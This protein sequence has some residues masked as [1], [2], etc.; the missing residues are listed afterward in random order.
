M[1]DE[2]NLTVHL[3]RDF[4]APVA[5][6][7]AAWKDPDFITKWWKNLTVAK[8][9]FREGGAIELRWES[10]D[11]VVTGHYR[12]IVE[13][14]RIVFTWKPK[15]ADESGDESVV[16]LAFEQRGDF[17]RLTLAHELNR[18]KKEA[19]SHHGGWT[20]ALEDFGATY[21]RV[22]SPVVVKRTVNADAA[23]VFAALTTGKLLDQ[24]FFTDCTAD[25]RVDGEYEIKWDSN[26]DPARAHKRF[27]RY[28]DVVE[29]ERIQFEWRGITLDTGD[30]PTIVTVELTAHGEQTDITLSHDGWGG[31][32]GAFESR[33]QHEM[34]WNF[35]VDNLGRYLTSGPDLRGAM[36]DQRVTS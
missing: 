14:E 15:P 17:T 11:G 8:L 10:W 21:P 28:L 7:F 5:K 3:Q 29:N 33:D 26:S 9:D 19:D 25:A 18:S 36:F 20:Q 27:G 2:L 1:S 30:T 35:Y 6:V 22:T 24:W 16:T 34:G 32:E 23:K 31:A 4:R 13:N 12:E